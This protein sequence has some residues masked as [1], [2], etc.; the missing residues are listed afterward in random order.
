[1]YVSRASGAFKL[2]G[3]LVRTACVFG[4]QSLSYC[5]AAAAVQHP[6]PNLDVFVFM[7]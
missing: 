3:G 2:E 7:F 6:E 4:I 1:M 5:R